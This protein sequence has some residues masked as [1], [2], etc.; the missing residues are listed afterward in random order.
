M[1]AANNPGRPQGGFRSVR[2]R[3]RGRDS[4]EDIRQVFAYIGYS[5]D[6]HDGDQGGDQ[7]I[8]NSG[9]TGFV[10]REGFDSVQHF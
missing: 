7:T 6:D 1:V 3:E 4:R 8:L 2:V 5:D 9:D 10:R